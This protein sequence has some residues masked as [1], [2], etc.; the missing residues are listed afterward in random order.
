MKRTIAVL[1]LALG[2]AFGFTSHASAQQGTV[3]VTVPFDFAVAGQ[4]LPQGD[5]R[6]GTFGNFVSFRDGEQKTHLFVRGFDGDA[7]TDGRS[8]L[9]FDN[10]E[11]NYFLRKI[12]TT[13]SNMNI[14]FPESNLEY[15]SRTSE[16]S[17]SIYAQNSGR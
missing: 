12:Q 11:G 5:Y 8:V 14:E 13:S 2:M 1:T 10:V 17:R 16:S 9:V 4:V 3:S 7:S 6:I 15:K